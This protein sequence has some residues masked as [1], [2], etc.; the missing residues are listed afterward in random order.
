MAQQKQ[1]R[2][3]KRFAGAPVRSMSTASD[4]RRFR[5]KANRG[6]VALKALIKNTQVDSYSLQTPFH[7][8]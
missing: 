2:W 1:N 5:A 3:D 6:K 8:F 4:Q 7:A